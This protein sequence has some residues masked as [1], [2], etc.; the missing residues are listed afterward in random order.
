[1]LAK[2]FAQASLFFS[3]GAGSVAAR[4][5][6]LEVGEITHGPYLPPEAVPAVGGAGLLLL[7]VVL[8][9]FGVRLL[10]GNHPRGSKWLLAACLTTALASGTSGVKLISDAYAIAGLQLLT[11]SGDTLTMNTS[12]INNGGGL[13]GGEWGSIVVENATGELQ[14]IINISL[15]PNCQIIPEDAVIVNA[16][17]GGFYQGPC[18]DRPPTALDP[19][20]TC[21]LD[22]C[23]ESEIAEGTCDDAIVEDDFNGK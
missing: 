9:L 19:G 17:N 18:S 14:Y 12:M 15:A 11:A 6:G 4:A 7:A 16:G 21:D 8:S 22:V 5:S 10:R 2:R 3:V 1:M 13:N 20:D 23:C